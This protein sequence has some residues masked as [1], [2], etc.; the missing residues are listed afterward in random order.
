MDDE[1]EKL[2]RHLKELVANGVRNL[3]LNL[4][5]LTQVDSSGVAVI[6]KAFVCLR[7]CGGELKLLCPCGRVLE[8]LTLFRLPE[9][10]P[11]FDDETQALASFRPERSY[12]ANP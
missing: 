12:A 6:I 8:V 1:S 5:G 11:S 7:D 10:I 4:A 2:D 9:I 3:L